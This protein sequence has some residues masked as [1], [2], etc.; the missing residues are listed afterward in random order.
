VL[1]AALALPAR[2]QEDG[3]CR[4]H[5]TNA[6]YN[7]VNKPKTGYD[8][9]PIVADDSLGFYVAYSAKQNDTN[10]DFSSTSCMWVL[11]LEKDEV[12]VFSGGFGDTWYVPGGAYFDADY[13][14]AMIRQ[15]V[16]GCMGRDLATTR[17]RFVAPHGHPDH[18]TVAFIKALER[19]GMSVVEIAYQEG[20]RAW[21]EQL[22]W[23]PHHPALFR[24]LPGASCWNSIRS[25][26]S[27]LGRVWFVHRPGHTPGSID[28][29]LDVLNDP[30]DRVLVLGSSAGG[31]SPPSGVQLTLSAHGTAMVGGPR[32]A[33]SEVLPGSGIN[34]QCL[35]TVTPPRIGSSWIVELDVSQH[36][37]ASS[38]YFFGT[39]CGLDPGILTSLG[40]LLVDPKGRPRLSLTRPIVSS[41][42]EYIGMDIPRDPALMGRESY[43][44]AAIIGG[45]TQLSN[46]LRIVIGF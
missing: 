1:L 5:A 37:G 17:V 35:A 44:Q 33:V 31:C 34:R 4:C 23:L 46:G 11:P 42:K 7:V 27:P 3:D 13:D 20:D 12:L 8:F 40:E 43:V 2:A 22:P 26:K 38:V 36:P 18:I 14:A 28:L 21:I 24:V 41:G 29:V 30:E 16:A 32:R 10:T 19:A 6:R 25:Y 39:D 9:V 15:I 45:K